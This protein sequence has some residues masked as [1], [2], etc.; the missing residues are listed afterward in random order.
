MLKLLLKIHLIF[1]QLRTNPETIENFI[2][3]FLPQFE[4]EFVVQKRLIQLNTKKIFIFWMR[5]KV[6][7]FIISKT[8]WIILFFHK[9][10]NVSVQV[11]EWDT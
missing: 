7:R 9:T 5:K 2:T 1:I 6:I 11:F 8:N 10:W 3:L 4:N